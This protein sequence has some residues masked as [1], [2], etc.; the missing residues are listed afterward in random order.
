MMLVECQGSDVEQIKEWPGSPAASW[1]NAESLILDRWAPIWA[2]VC[3][4]GSTNTPA[5][6]PRARRVSSATDAQLQKRESEGSLAT[7]GAELFVV[8]FCFL[9]THSVI[10]SPNYQMIIRSLRYMQFV[11]LECFTIL[12]LGFRV[13]S[14][15]LLITNKRTTAG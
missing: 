4:W 14:V 2:R 10:L 3:W 15:K 7:S 8:L 11:S 1:M 9:K 12:A 13:L 5:W 6:V